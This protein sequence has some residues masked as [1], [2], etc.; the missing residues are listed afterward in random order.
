MLEEKQERILKQEEDA[1]KD[2][3]A[4]EREASEKVTS[5]AT[6]K[7]AKKRIKDQEELNE[8]LK[9][10]EFLPISLIPKRTLAFTPHFTHSV[11]TGK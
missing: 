3:A 10:T 9:L 1:L 4:A 7:A 11:S 5:A 2:I 8:D 6:E